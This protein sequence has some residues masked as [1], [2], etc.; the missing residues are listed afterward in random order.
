[1][2]LCFHERIG[3]RIHFLQALFC[4]HKH[5]IILSL[6]PHHALVI[7]AFVTYEAEVLQTA[8]PLMNNPSLFSGHCFP[9][10]EMRKNCCEKETT[11]NHLRLK[12]S[13]YLNIPTKT[14]KGI[15]GSQ[16]VPVLFCAVLTLSCA[17]FSVCF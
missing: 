3:D 7:A 9:V 10:S 5:E 11:T 2:E 16:Q 1:M 12:C 17:Y 14:C 4:C 15:I 6:W 13:V 8:L